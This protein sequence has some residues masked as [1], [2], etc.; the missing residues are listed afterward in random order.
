LKY[1]PAENKGRALKNPSN[2]CSPLVQ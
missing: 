2:Y 1:F